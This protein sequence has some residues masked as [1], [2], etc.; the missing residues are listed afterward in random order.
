MREARSGKNSVACQEQAWGEL[1]LATRSHRP[2]PTKLSHLVAFLTVTCIT[3]ALHRYV[4]GH[5]RR[6]LLRDY[7]TLG[8]RLARIAGW[9]FVVM[10]T[11]FLFVYFRNRI[12]ADLST[13]SRV[14]TYPFSVWLAVTFLWAV[15]LV[16]VTLFRHRERLGGR[17]AKQVIARARGRKRSPQDTTRQHHAKHLTST[18]HT[19]Q[20]PRSSSSALT[21]L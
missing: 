17:V 10:D 9:F 13:A 18:A 2:M 11:P 1:G 8:P 21:S 20:E 4:Y 19:A 14:I 15:L 12:N 7:P 6:V 16:P 5:L 3:L